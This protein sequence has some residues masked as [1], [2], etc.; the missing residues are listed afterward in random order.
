MIDGTFRH[1]DSYGWRRAD[2][3]WRDAVDDRGWRHPAHRG[4]ARGSSSRNGGLF[5]WCSAVGQLASGALEV[6]LLPRYQD[7]GP[8]PGDVA[9]LRDGAA[10]VRVIAGDVDGHQGRDRPIR[11]SRRAHGASTRRRA[12]LALATRLQ[13]ARVRARRARHRRCRRAAGHDRP[14]GGLR[15]WRLRPAAR[16][17][18]TN[19]ATP[20]LDVLLLGGQPIREPVVAHGPFVMNTRERDH[21]GLRGLR[22]RPTGPDPGR[23][24]NPLA[25]AAAYR[26]RS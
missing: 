1:R 21:P 26:R 4:A 2:H 8:G 14:A 15:G 10:L 25:S 3:R 5:H 6:G 19:A 23:A 13:C 7:I 12:R 22:G 18:A 17:R 20:N 24:L 16:R 9:P 11:P